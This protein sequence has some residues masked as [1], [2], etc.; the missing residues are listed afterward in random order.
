MNFDNLEQEIPFCQGKEFY[1]KSQVQILK[2]QEGLTITLTDTNVNDTPLTPEEQ[3][4]LNKE[5]QNLSFD[6]TP[7]HW[8]NSYNLIETAPGVLILSP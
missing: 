6:D 7:D 5:L 3:N 2:N 1:S 4:Q 8:I